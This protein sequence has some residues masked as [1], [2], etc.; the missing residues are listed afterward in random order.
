MKEH[1]SRVF[2][3][4]DSF[5]GWSGNRPSESEKRAM[6]RTIV[7]VGGAG[8][9]GCKVAQRLLDKGDRVFITSRRSRSELPG[10]PAGAEL[11]RADA[12][13]DAA[14]LKQALSEIGP[15]DV[16]Y[17]MLGAFMRNPVPI[18]IDGS[19]NIAN[20]LPVSKQPTRFIFCSTIAVYGH[21]PNEI[22]SEDSSIRDDFLIGRIHAEAEQALLRREEK[23]ELVVMVL[24]LPHVFGPG[25]ERVFDMYRRG[26]FLI[27]GDGRNNMHHLYIDDL[28]EVM[29]RSADVDIPTA[30]VY[31]I[32]DAM[33]QPYHA[34]I[35]FITDW[36]GVPRLRR[37]SYEQALREGLV[38]RY[39]GPLY[40]KPDVLHELFRNLEAH[41]AIDNRLM[42]D[43]FRFPLKSPTFEPGVIEM[44]RLLGQ[45]QCSESNNLSS[46]GV[47]K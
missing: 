13:N 38:E 15:I 37:A 14:G 34:Y 26:E 42:R 10:V 12:V 8:D 23:G 5:T 43:T 17:D 18:V 40:T 33:N 30:G 9:T 47:A 22:L 24:R 11:L 41:I 4:S 19:R 1:A 45:P 28:I 44:M 6:S 29:I 3:A 16:V 32:V 35:D 46:T 31:N 27:L 2:H 25:R 21:R 39:L 36:C 7:L 20:A